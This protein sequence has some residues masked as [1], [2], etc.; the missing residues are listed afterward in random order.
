MMNERFFNEI[1]M[2]V[3]LNGNVVAFTNTDT[4]MT[5]KSTMVVF[6]KM[7][8]KTFNFTITLEEKERITYLVELAKHRR[9]K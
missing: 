1:M 6:D 4:G 9:S 3:E 2:G 5:N 8:D 7:L